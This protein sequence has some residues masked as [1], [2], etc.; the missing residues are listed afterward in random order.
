MGQIGPH[1]SLG[2]P[3]NRP[4]LFT[5][6]VFFFL[7]WRVVTVA[8]ARTQTFMV[9]GYGHSCQSSIG[10]SV[11]SGGS[12]VGRWRLHPAH[13]PKCSQFR[14]V[15][16]KFWQNHMLAISPRVAP[17]LRGVLDPPLVSVVDQVSVNNYYITGISAMNY[18]VS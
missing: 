16:R 10:M 1:G 4:I 18:G 6:S 2:G 13:C 5:E 7:V 17:P 12:K 8:G 11:S 15:F 9:S 14:A 3:L